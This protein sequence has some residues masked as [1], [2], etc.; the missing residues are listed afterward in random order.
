MILDEAHNIE[1]TC[2][3][4][5]SYTFTEQEVFATADDLFRKCMHN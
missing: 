4:A 1:D 5:A 2:R 3:E